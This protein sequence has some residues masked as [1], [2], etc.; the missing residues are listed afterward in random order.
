[1]MGVT[2]GLPAMNICITQTANCISEL[3]TEERSLL[4]IIKSAIKI[5]TLCKFILLLQLYSK[6]KESIF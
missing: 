3:I 6:G 1:M 2:G 4:S 5:D